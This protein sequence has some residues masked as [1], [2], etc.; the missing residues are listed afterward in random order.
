VIRN[1]QGEKF[2]TLFLAKY[3]QKTRK[4]SYINAGHNPPILYANGEAMP[5]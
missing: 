1:T 5:H 3:N 2:I 4:L